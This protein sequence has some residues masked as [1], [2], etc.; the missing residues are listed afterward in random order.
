MRVF[1][2]SFFK[3]VIVLIVCVGAVFSSKIISLQDHT[4]ATQ[5]F[6]AAVCKQIYAREGVFSSIEKARLFKVQ[7]FA[8]YVEGSITF[9]VMRD[10]DVYKIV[11]GICVDTED[12]TWKRLKEKVIEGGIVYELKA[13][14]KGHAIVY[15]T[16]SQLAPLE[17]RLAIILDDI[18]NTKNYDEIFFSLPNSI[19]GAILPQLRYSTYFAEA[20]HDQGREVMLHLPM[21]NKR[22]LPLGPG[23]LYSA[24]GKQEL[25][26]ELSR[27]LASVPTCIGVNNH[28]GSRLTASTEHMDL[29][30]T[31]LKKKGLFFIDSYT[32]G[33]SIAYELGRKK[34]GLTGKRDIFLDNKDDV[35]YIKGQLRQ[36]IEMAQEKGRVIAIGHYRKKTMDVILSMLP[37]IEQSG[38]Q[39]VRVSELIKE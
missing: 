5:S 19:T 16:F 22:G 29:I 3:A 13:V 17:P 8:R 24:M 33:D 14:Y 11:Q 28:M 25:L 20:S 18:G 31:A 34:K 15:L 38:V 9:N 6:Y 39:L 10:V 27:N 30:L 26:S 1:S 23:G 12:V 7:R 32:S 35:T 2:R 21:E 4:A 37:G 36:A